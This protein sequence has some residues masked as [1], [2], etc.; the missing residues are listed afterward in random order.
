DQRGVLGGEHGPERPDHVGDRLA[1]LLGETGGLDDLAGLRLV[2]ADERVDGDTSQRLGPLD[3]ELLDLHAALDAAHR[4]VAALGAVEEDREVVLLGDRGTLGDHHAV[5][6]VAL[7]VHAEDLGGPL[8]GLLGGAGDLD[9]ARLAAATGLHLGLDDDH[10]AVGGEQLAGR[11]LRLLGGG[12]DDAAQH[13]DTVLLED[14]TRLV[15]EQVHR[16]GLRRRLRKVTPTLPRPER[17]DARGRPLRRCGRRHPRAASRAS[18]GALASACATTSANRCMPSMSGWTPSGCS[19]SRFCVIVP[20]Q[21]ATTTFG[22]CAAT[23]S[24]VAFDSGI[25]LE[26]W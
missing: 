4:E 11:G 13:G 3:R 6:G 15:L 14:V 12:D 26:E 19:W 22:C 10:A 17:P 2:D 21:S 25:Q 23:A 1:Q 9:A 24:M 7:D 8:A 20:Y 5:D 18:G 16:S